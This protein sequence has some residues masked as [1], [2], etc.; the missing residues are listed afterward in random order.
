[1]STPWVTR[2]LAVAGVMPAPAFP[3]NVWR[4]IEAALPLSLVEIPYLTSASVTAWLDARGVRCEL[5][6]PS[7]PLHG[8]L[9]ARAGTGFVFLNGDDPVDVQRFTVAHEGAHFI[10]DHLLPRVDALAAFGEQIRPVIDGVRQPTPGESLRSVLARVPLGMQTHLM[11]RG[12]MGHIQ[13]WSVENA[14]QRADRLALEIVAPRRAVLETIRS[15][16][17]DAAQ[18]EPAT[19]DLVAAT[20]GLPRSIAAA[21]TTSALSVGRIATADLVGRLFGIPEDR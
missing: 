16:Q 13:C 1:V 17:H 4:D 2:A 9:V 10:A 11:T 8:C 18:V 20:Y 7:R 19:I 12:P 6:G 3:R 14:E 15:A 21:C 5:H